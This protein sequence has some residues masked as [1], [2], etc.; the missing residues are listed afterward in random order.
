MSYP[1]SL[2]ALQQIFLFSKQI[3]QRRKEKTEIS[4][5]SPVLPILLIRLGEKYF[6]SVTVSSSVNQGEKHWLWLKGMF[7]WWNM[8]MLAKIF[9]KNKGMQN[10]KFHEQETG[11]CYI[12]VVVQLLNHVW[13]FMTQWT[14]TRQA[15][16]SL[17]IS[18]SLPKFFFIALVI[19]S[20][21]IAL[22]IPSSPLILWR[23]LLLPSIFPSIRGFSSESS[24]LIK[25]PKYWSFSF[26]IN[27]SSENSGLISLKIDWFDLAGQRTFKE[28]SP[29]P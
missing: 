18:Q 10:Y 1:F 14:A 16:L 5:F 8:I 13:L 11:W 12:V 20:N 28:S 7:W 23:P 24:V 27:I 22:V 29:A 25:Q 4:V 3:K 26:S 2:L 9:Y 6:I 15:S 19:P 17:T 21:L